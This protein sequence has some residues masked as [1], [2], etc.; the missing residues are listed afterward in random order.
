MNRSEEVRDFYERMPYPAPLTNLDEHLDLY[1]NPLRRR[2][3]FHLIWPDQRPRENQEILIAGCGTSQAAK[4]ALREPDARITAIDVSDASL[5]HTR[6]L[7][8]KYNLE[9]LEL[10]QAP[11]RERLRAWSLFRPGGLHRRAASPARPGPRSSR[12]SR[13]PA[14]GRRDARDGL[15]TL[16]PGR[17]LYDAGVLPPARN[18]PVGV[19]SAKSRRHARRAAGGPS[20]RERAAARQR[21]PA[22]GSDGGRAP[23]SPGSRLFR[24]GNVCVA[25]S[26][27]HVVW[28]LGRAG[29]LS[30]PMR[31][32]GEE[33]ARRAARLAA[34]AGAARR[35]RAFS[36]NHGL[37]QFHRVP[38][39]SLRRGP[40]DHLRRRPVGAIMFRSRCPGRCASGNVCLLAA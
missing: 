1:K 38:R 22:T 16:W 14:T 4:Y 19:G 36:R 35:R 7:Q 29:A 40:A 10:H 20:D 30:A 9:N 26:V 2:A 8:R 25:R 11:D 24:S 23:S 28:S 13:C 5:R 37:A 31:R 32:P 17:N 39:R 27:R 34:L 33:S 21:F 3:E 15:R 18:P 6:D 12:A